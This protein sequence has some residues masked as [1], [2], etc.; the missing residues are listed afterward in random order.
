[1]TNRLETLKKRYEEYVK[2]ED[3]ILNGE[4]ENKST[5]L[6]PGSLSVVI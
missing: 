3:T 4:Q 5:E 2:A 6:E 1:M